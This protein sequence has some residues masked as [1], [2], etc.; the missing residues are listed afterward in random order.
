MIE[1]QAE[2][3]V[4]GEDLD[5][6]LLVLALQYFQNYPD[7]LHHPKEDVLYERLVARDATVGNK[8][9]NIRKDHLRLAAETEAVADELA[10]AQSQRASA[11][12]LA[13][14]LQRFVEHYR[15]HMTIEE[16]ELFPRARTL[17]DAQD[18]A[19]ID[20]EIAPA[21][22]PLFDGAASSQ[23]ERLFN[24]LMRGGS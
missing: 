9:V 10:M 8:I 15:R 17:L 2:G 22:D 21:V 3:V 14:R 18:W 6:G 12:D 4:R 16:A 5:L 7:L 1:R 20:A 11:V 19:Y 24:A 13:A 23:Y